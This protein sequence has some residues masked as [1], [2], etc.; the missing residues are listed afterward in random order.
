MQVNYNFTANIVEVTPPLVSLAEDQ[1]GNYDNILNSV[2]LSSA[3]C[4]LLYHKGEAKELNGHC[5][6]ASLITRS[7]QH[8]AGAGF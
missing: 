3:C 5:S 6:L 8:Q 7:P 2:Y 4:L 1:M